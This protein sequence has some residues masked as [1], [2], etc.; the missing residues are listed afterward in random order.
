MIDQVIKRPIVTE[1]STVGE[2]N[3]KY[4]FAVTN[5]ATKVSVKQAI[6]QLYGVKVK[7]VNITYIQPKS[8][9]VGRGRT[10]TK[11]NLEKKATITL[12]KGKTLDIHKLA[13]K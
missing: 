9:L 1:K 3:G 4:V 11:R 13:K 6:E 7:Q 2:E 5:R 12:E 8:R 10:Y